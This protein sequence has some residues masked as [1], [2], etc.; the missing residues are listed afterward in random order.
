[1]ASAPSL[2]L[3]MAV[4]GV[5]G[6]LRA[7]CPNAPKVLLKER[8]IYSPCSQNALAEGLFAAEIPRLFDNWSVFNLPTRGSP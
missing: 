3:S 8:S 2:S 1:M 6:M 7:F 4:R 5:Q